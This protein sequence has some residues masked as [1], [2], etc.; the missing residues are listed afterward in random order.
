M[1]DIELNDFENM[2]NINNKGKNSNFPFEIKI[3][4]EFDQQSMLS[5]F[6]NMDIKNSFNKMR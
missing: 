6:K 5:I 4:N 1:P 3:S 2:N